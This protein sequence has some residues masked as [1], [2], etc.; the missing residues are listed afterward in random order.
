MKKRLLA[1][2]LA[3][4]MTFSLLP[5]ISLGA[6]TATMNVK[7][8]ANTD[9][10][11]VLTSV[12]GAPVY[13]KNKQVTFTDTGNNAFTGWVQEPVTVNDEATDEWNVKFYYDDN[14]SRW[15][16]I[17]K[18]AKMDAYN[19][20]TSLIVKDAVPIVGF[21][22]SGYGYEMRM[23]VKED[24]YLEGKYMMS[25]YGTSTRWSSL[26]I[27]GENNATI[28]GKTA[29]YGI[30]TQRSIYLNVNIDCVCPS[31]NT[32]AY[33]NTSD[34]TR[35]FRISGGNYNIHA[36][37]LVN[38]KTHA[39]QLY[40][41]SITLTGATKF[42]SYGS[43]AF[44]D[45]V[46]HQFTDLDGNPVALADLPVNGG[47]KFVTYTTHMVEDC[48]AGGTCT[49]CAATVEA[50]TE[51]EAREDDGNCTT[52]ITCK[53]CDVV[54]TEAAASHIPGEPSGDC[55]VAVKC[56]NCNVVTTP[57][58]EHT[59]KDP[60][61]QNETAESYESVVYCSECG[62]E[63][64]REVI[65]KLCP[66]TNSTL[67]NQ[68][69]PTCTK[70]GLAIYHCSDCNEDYEV[71]L[72]SPGHDHQ[73][74]TIVG[75]TIYDRGYT[76]YTCTVCGNT[77][78]DDY[79]DMIL[80][81]AII[82]S[83]PYFSLKEAVE[84]AQPGDV[85]I[86]C[87]SQKTGEGVY[88]DKDLTIDFNGCYYSMDKA[89]DGAAMLIARDTT[90]TLKNSKPAKEGKLCI[91]Y[92]NADGVCSVNFSNLIKNYGTLYV[93]DVFLNGNNTFADFTT[94][95]LFNAGTAYLG[96]GTKVAAR[97]LALENEGTLTKDKSVEVAAPSGFHFD[98]A[99]GELEH[100][101][102]TSTK[103][104]ATVYEVAYTLHTCECGESFRENTGTTKLPIYAKIPA[105]GMHYASLQEAIDAAE[106]GQL[107]ELA[108]RNKY[109]T[110]IV[111]PAGKKLTIDMK[112]YYHAITSV[113]NGAGLIIE[114]GAELNLVSSDATGRFMIEFSAHDNSAEPIQAVVKNYG[115]LTA[116]NIHI[117]GNNLY[118]TGNFAIFNY[119]SL[120][121]KDNS[122]ITVFAETNV[123]EIAG[124]YTEDKSDD[125]R[126]ADAEQ[127]AYVDVQKSASAGGAITLHPGSD[128]TYTITITNNNGVPVSLNITDTMPRYATFVGGCDDVRDKDLHWVVKNLQPG[129]S[130]TVTYTINNTITLKQVKN[131]ASD[132]IVK[133]TNVKVAGKSV[134]TATQDI[135]VLETFNKEDRRKI[136][137]GIDSM[138]T[139]N[140]TAK[141]SSKL[142]LNRLPLATMMY[143]V[144]FSAGPGFGSL[145]DPADV[146]VMIYEKAGENSGGSSSGG[147][148]DVV[149]TAGNLLDKVVP[150]LYGGTAVSA[151]KDAL[152][153]GARATEVKV[154]DLISGDM[155]FVEN[156]GATKLYIFDGT[157]LVELAETKVTTNIAP[158]TVLSTLP[159][160]DRYAVLRISISYNITFAL[161]EGEYFNEADKNG[162]TDMEKALIAT[163]ESYLLRGD[164]NQY[165]DDM[166]GISQ[167]RWQSSLNLPE[168]CT[169]DQYG[170]SNCAAF[171]YDVHWATYGVA[172]KAKNASGSSVS[173]NTTA[174]LASATSRGWDPET[175]TGDNASSIFYCT[176]MVKDAS[177]KYVSTMTAEEQAATKELIISL[178]RPGDI[179]CIRRTTSSGHA[180]LYAG[181]GTIIHSSGSSYSD[182]NKTD[183]HE[184]TI[185]FRMVEDLFDPSIYNSTSYVFNLVSFSI[186][187]LQ[188]LKSDAAPTENT[189]N[190]V[191][192]MQ[193]VCAEKVSSTA[194]GKTVNCGD[195]ITYTFHIFN[196]NK[197]EKAFAIRD[198][199]DENVTF[200][201]A[202]NGG[203]ADGSNISW[204][205][206]VPAETRVSVSY[207]VKVKD[208]LANYT[209]INNT[210]ATINGVMHRCHNTY[211]ANTLTTDQQQTLLAAIETVKGMDVSGLN[212]VELVELIY[213]TAFG[214]DDLFG[215]K[216]TNFSMLLD[217]GANQDKNNPV[218]GEDNVGIFNDTK[219]WSSTSSTTT[220]RNAVSFMDSNTSK[221]A[222][223]VAPGM[224][225]GGLVYNSS[226][227][228]DGRDERSL[229]YKDIDGSTV[230]RSRYY[231]EKDLVIGDVYV[232]KGSSSEWLFIYV[233]NN[234]FV[235][236]A[237]GTT[238][239]VFE[240][241]S[242]SYLFEYT[243]HSTWKKH[244]VLRPSITLDI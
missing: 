44:K 90:V 149:D 144:G 71:V 115:T 236:M 142:P 18:G 188:N 197:A 105:T 85:I 241:V 108:Q 50:R 70:D 40:G 209:E 34:G 82:G 75:A 112:G 141:N 80:P 177:G 139:G 57:A 29:G 159:A 62:S 26:T 169:I 164:R 210:K 228:K 22:S 110:T 19:D 78:N 24:S 39:T 99:T 89:Y 35:Y 124:N 134:P 102:Y 51:H 145:V 162:Y 206:V 239:D 203:V 227:N 191:E 179:I 54:T 178:L 95:T 223:M 81:I 61:I 79:T 213:K 185:R 67:L 12:K 28:Y 212:S 69:D 93:Q 101:S 104:D 129:D 125:A 131:A 218:L 3:I 106:N 217:G 120:T 175:L 126:L 13:T 244:A 186:V 229:R 183:T 21:G 135:W 171:T 176:P 130:H 94:S 100:H 160:S 128:V 170:Y 6:T 119:N 196:T 31:A 37:Q 158:E 121:L 83:T 103:H 56:V 133:N 109:G 117:N 68:E 225:G 97:T 137:M 64:S 30:Y 231:W 161:K 114:E 224:W 77:Y 47:A 46:C 242:V 36:Y 116:E 43:I 49:R 143:Y 52:A 194:M 220:N 14:A 221:P 207:T 232:L 58:K 166:T 172:H 195:E 38:S 193:G 45:G 63:I 205:I 60:E 138:V 147:V 238:Y 74:A 234:T 11:L 32:F 208:G 20:D 136:E 204:D 168:D 113:T 55:T 140:L 25:G 59:P 226:Y 132:I 222:L 48:I 15:S 180:M 127:M 150:T 1:L 237:A 42:A 198:I 107:I 154:T 17:L 8:M 156:D 118:G 2:V 152:F 216:V 9:Y 23:V 157:Y 72:T 192:N 96:S 33:L 87:R 219:Y 153:R 202:T 7:L 233:G 182:T 189:L 173:M 184:A 163:A 88:I 151:D 53:Y 165:T 122:F 86:I 243:P 211:V 200:V 92:S 4:V 111:I 91:T 41:G 16:M 66:H 167:F 148:E 76:V 215:E 174:N 190:R 27:N 146:L 98:E 5:V 199:L 235:T 123:G 201:S 73:I 187:R 214:V 240:E 10:E 65:S 155:V 230:L 84:A 181:N